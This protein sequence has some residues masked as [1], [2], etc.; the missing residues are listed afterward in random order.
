VGEI[1]PHKYKVGPL[2]RQMMEDY[3]VEVR[4]LPNAKSKTVAA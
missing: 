1:G 4:R 2:T 3:S